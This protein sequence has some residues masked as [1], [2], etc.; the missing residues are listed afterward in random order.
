MISTKL[1]MSAYM[2]LYLNSPKFDTDEAEHVGIN[3]TLFEFG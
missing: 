2:M 1:S 3:N